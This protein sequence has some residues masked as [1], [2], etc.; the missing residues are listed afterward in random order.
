MSAASR[1]LDDGDDGA[2][3]DEQLVSPPSPWHGQAHATAP[4]GLSTFFLLPLFIAKHPDLPWSHHG[5]RF[6]ADRAELGTRS[7]TEKKCLGTCSSVQW[8]TS[9]FSEH[10]HGYSSSCGCTSMQSSRRGQRGAWAVADMEGIKRSRLRHL[11]LL[12][13]GSGAQ[14]KQRC[15]CSTGMGTTPRFQ[16]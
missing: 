12:R 7:R 10:V 16:D 14:L 8:N 3:P 15:R 6:G 5:T 11:M 13:L 2:A 4:A 9:E 1:F